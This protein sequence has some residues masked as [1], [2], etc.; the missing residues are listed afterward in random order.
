MPLTPW[1]PEQQ[2]PPIPACAVV[3]RVT[4]DLVSRRG[5]RNDSGACAGWT[6]EKPFPSPGNQPRLERCS[7]AA[8][9]PFLLGDDVAVDLTFAREPLGRVGEQLA[10][11]IGCQGL[12]EASTG[13]A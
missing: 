13:E 12:R 11:F 3:Q 1:R 2:P 5:P 8:A 6:R 10:D 7:G 9:L 4:G